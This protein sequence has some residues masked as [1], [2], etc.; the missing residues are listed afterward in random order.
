MSQHYRPISSEAQEIR[1]VVLS[2]ST[3]LEAPPV[4]QL[5]YTSL[6]DE[7]KFEALSYVWGDNPLEEP[8]QILLDSKPFLVK[9]NLDK[10]LRH[11]RHS[12]TNR[13]LWVD[14]I[15]IDQSNLEERSHQVRLMRDIFSHCVTNLF[16]LGPDDRRSRLTRGMEVMKSLVT[17][18][19]YAAK[20]SKPWGLSLDFFHESLPLRA[21]F[22]RP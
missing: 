9:H 14:A 7:I 1:L 20:L 11:L 15:S 12:D 17:D 21:V 18:E 16:W 5:L 6:T 3:E 13:I 10:A 19:S 4:C 8:K 22:K 2:P